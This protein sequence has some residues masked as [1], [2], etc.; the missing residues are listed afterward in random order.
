MS[1]VW[2]VRHGHYSDQSI[3]G[4]FTSEALADA[5]VLQAYG[6]QGADS[7]VSVDEHELDPEFVERGMR[8]FDV[9]V[10]ASGDIE[11]VDTIE[12]LKRSGI[13]RTERGF[14]VK[15]FARDAAHA[16]KLATE[17]RQEE[18]ARDVMPR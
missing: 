13:E 3:D 8:G 7:E 6:E 10:T 15:C 18:M 2:L 16:R 5:Y 14:W 11:G 9:L 1:S 4:V 12:N 17:K